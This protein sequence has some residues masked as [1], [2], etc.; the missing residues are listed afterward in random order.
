MSWPVTEGLELSLNA[1]DSSE[2][3][4]S[5]SC[6]IFNKATTFYVLTF[7]YFGCSGETE[8]TFIADLSVGLATVLPCCIQ[9]LGYYHSDDQVQHINA[10]F[11]LNRVKLRLELHAG[12]SVLLNITRLVLFIHYTSFSFH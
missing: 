2:K 9:L 3:Y 7:L 12:L 8:D 11:F 10:S 5:Y 6:K 4:K 1:D